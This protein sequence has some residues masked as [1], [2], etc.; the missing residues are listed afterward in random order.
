MMSIQKTKISGNNG[1]LELT[2]SEK[3]DV[4]DYLKD[5]IARRR[6]DITKFIH[7]DVLKSIM[8]GAQE[9]CESKY[10]EGLIDYNIRHG[11]GEFQY[12]IEL[13]YNKSTLTNAKSLFKALLASTS[14]FDGMRGR[15]VSRRNSEYSY[16]LMVDCNDSGNVSPAIHRL[17][18]FV[19]ILSI[20]KTF[21]TV[22]G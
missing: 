20:R 4:V 22:Y 1:L 2:R 13:V 11:T 8:N 18:R 7:Q 3:W 14:N 19:H 5:T 17:A 12:R 10:M 16:E 9:I 21:K 6:P 15:C